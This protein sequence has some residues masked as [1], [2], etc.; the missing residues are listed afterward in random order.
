M[1]PLVLVLYLYVAL[2]CIAFAISAGY[3]LGVIIGRTITLVMTLSTAS[4]SALPRATACFHPG[5]LR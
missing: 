5:E 1:H 4:P 3:A 2:I